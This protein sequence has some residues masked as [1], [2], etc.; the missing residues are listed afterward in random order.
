MDEEKASLYPLPAY[1]YDPA[2]RAHGRVDR[3]STVRFDTNN[4]SVPIA[5]SGKEVSIK[6]L[7][8]TV[9][10]YSGG[11]QIAQHARCL[12]H[13]QSI[14][15]I[16]HY[17]PLLERKGRSIFQA[18]PVRNNVPD[19]FLSW[20]EKQGFTPKQLVALLH[21]CLVEGYDAVMKNTIYETPSTA[22]QDDVTVQ[23]VDLA[24]YDTLFAGK[25]GVR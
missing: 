11:A 25:A 24:A 6:A 3:F 14:Y 15:S 1:R 7:P 17:L 13:K 20:L 8:E 10:I 18:K 9:E 2:K 23:I 22:I 12:A 16:E 19:Y 21:R 5:Y 4:Y